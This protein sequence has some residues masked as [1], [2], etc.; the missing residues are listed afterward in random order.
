M[1]FGI[2][3]N[4]GSGRRSA[5][6]HR[7]MVEQI[8]ADAAA[9]V[10][11]VVYDGSERIESLVSRMVSKIDILGIV[12]GDGTLNGAVNGVM[13]SE[14]PE[15]P[16]FFLPAGRGSDTARTLPA[17][18]P[19]YANVQS[20]PYRTRKIDLGLLSTHGGEFKYFI[21]ESSIGLGAFAA[22]SASKLPR[23]IGGAA[24]L[25][26]TIHSL[27]RSPTTDLRLIIDGIG[28][29]EL[30][31]CHHLTVANG[32]YF[33][34]GLQIAPS[35]SAVDGLLD[36]IAIAD[37][38]ASRIARALPQLLSSSHL[39]HPNVQHWKSTGV[40]IESSISTLIETDGEQ[41]EAVP[42]H[43]SLLPHALTWLEPI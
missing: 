23:R 18:T 43:Y 32:R 38:G 12:G 16:V 25:I 24:Y 20:F 11:L 35:A 19:S 37:A 42:D 33:G 7:S 27:L 29:F 6:R 28:T 36:I 9:D 14:N 22:R 40:T 2:L 15:V 13:R 1:R 8:S 10:A 30:P 34:A 39:S 26:G 21:N 31:R 17:L 41:W 4:P 5:A 3:I